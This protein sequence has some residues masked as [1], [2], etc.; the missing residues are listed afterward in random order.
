MS[1]RFATLRLLALLGGLLLASAC[2]AASSGAAAAPFAN[3]DQYVTLPAPYQRYSDTGKV[4]VVEVFSYGC[5]HC[6]EFAPYAEKLRKS[7]PPGVVFKL[8]PA[9]F[10]EEWIPYA[11]A[12]YA[13]HK[14]GVAQR[15]HLEFF[16]EKFQQNYP[17]NSLEDMS[18]FY[19]RA[20]VNP[21]EFMRIARSPAATAALQSDLNLIRKWGVDG[22]PTIV[23]DGK[24]RSNDVASYPQ[25]VKLTRWLVQRELAAKGGKP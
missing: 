11:R 7:L 23:V 10:N 24:Y 5:I 16:R 20:G 4:E 14:L 1:K 6:A 19:A 17:L 8:V 13:A 2:S 25:L 21:I 22:T 9:P 3:G 18:A 15:T 12:Y